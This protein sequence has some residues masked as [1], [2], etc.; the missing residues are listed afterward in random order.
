MTPSCAQ[1]STISTSRPRATTAGLVPFTSKGG[2]TV[3]P[4]RGTKRNVQTPAWFNFGKP[5]VLEEK[6]KR[7]TIIPEPSYSIPIALTGITGLSAVEGNL[8]LAGITGFLAAF[9]AF[10]A[11][12]VQFVFDDEALEVLIKSNESESK[13]SENKFVGGRNRW[14]Y[15]SFTNWEFWWKKLPVL[16]YFKET[17]TK[18]EGQIH[19]FPVLFKGNQLYDVMAERCGSSQNSAPTERAEIEE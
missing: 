10:Q 3:A 17:Q 16:V 9:L 6:V 12:R 1:V 18:P 11:S 7:E 8:V 4:S 5:K 14:E 2:R 19:F 13:E 15:D